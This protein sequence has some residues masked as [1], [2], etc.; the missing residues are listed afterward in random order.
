[1][2][3]RTTTTT[4]TPTPEDSIVTPYNVSGNVDYDKLIAQFGSS[5]L[6][7]ELV[8]RIGSATHTTPH[9][10]LRREIFFSHRD[11]DQILNQHE[12]GKTFYLYTGR[13]PSSESLHFGHLIPFIFT[14]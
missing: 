10:W 14:K 5:P 12:S 2:T 3:D 4:S 8:A 9:R 13:G 11:L 1:M 6:T 7:S